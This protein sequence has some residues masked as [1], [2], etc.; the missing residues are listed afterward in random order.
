MKAGKFLRLGLG[1]LIAVC[2]ATSAST[3][4]AQE[5]ANPDEVLATTT[6]TVKKTLE[7]R[8]T[9]RKE[10]LSTRLTT[11]QTTRLAARCEAAQAKITT[12]REKVAS[13][14]TNRTTAYTNIQTKLND[15]ATKLKSKVDTTQLEAELEV[16]DQKIS[17]FSTAVTTFQQTLADL[18]EVKCTEDAS[19]FRASLDAAKTEQTAVSNAAKAVRTQVQDV[20][21]PLLQAIRT[22]LAKGD[23]E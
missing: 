20:I 22:E 14:I 17:D 1:L 11:A 8:L 5:V 4:L 3:A 13:G 2:L 21:K 12:H 9:E 23:S 15:L 18:K 7:E 6:S 16:L 10:A 19:G